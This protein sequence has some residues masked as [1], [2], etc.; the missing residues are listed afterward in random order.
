M[1][2]QRWRTWTGSQSQVGHL[3]WHR[4]SGLA[5]SLCGH[6]TAAKGYRKPYQRKCIKC[7]AAQAKVKAKA[8]QRWQLDLN[9]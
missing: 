7:Q 5:V 3:M 2:A 8:E 9:K 1:L 6:Y 4:E